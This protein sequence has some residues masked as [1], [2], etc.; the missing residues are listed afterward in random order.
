MRFVAALFFLLLAGQASAATLL[1]EYRLEELQW[2]GAAAEV[3]DTSGNNRH[4]QAIGSPLPTPVDAAPAR[5][6][7]PGTCA[8][9]SFPGPA[10]NGGALSIGG[11]PVS[12]APG[13]KTSVSFWMYW[14]G[15][16]SVMPMGWNRHDLWLVNGHFGFN[17]GNSDVYGISS[18]GLANRWTHV[19][20]EFT[21]GNVAA[22]ALYIDGVA[23][24]LTQRQS[25]PNN[26]YSYANATLR[27]GGWQTDTNYRFS[28]RI[29]EVKVF[30]GQL[31]PVEVTT[32]FNETHV[33]APRLT[34]EWRLDECALGTVV[35][36]V[37][38]ASGNG[39]HGT[40]EGA[41]NTGTG[42]V[43]K[44]GIFNGVTP[45]RIKSVSNFADGITND[46]TI[47]FWVN[48]SGTH[49]IDSQSTS[50][51]GG[52]SGQRYALYPAQ[53][54]DAW[55]AGHAGVGV[56]VG[57][58]GVSVYEHAASYM[59]A[60]LVWP[61]AV[62]G[63]THVAVVY[64]ARQPKL[65]INGAL[66]ATGLTSTYANVHP[67]LRTSGGT[68]TNDGGLGGGNWGWFNGGID[69]FRIYDGALDAAQVASIATV[70]AR[71]C[72]SCAT[73][74]HYR[75]E[76][77]G[78]T[79]VPAEVLDTSGN[80]RHGQA[81]G[82]PLPVPAT[83]SPARAG[84]PGTCGYGDFNGGAL[85]LP[86]A[87]NTAAGAKTTVSFWMYWNGANSV[88][89]VGWFR[90]DLWLVSGHFGFNTAA[91]DVFGI[92]SAG[93]ANRWVH[94]S[95]VFTNGS[96]ASNKLYIDGVPQT[97]TQRQNTPSLGN[98]VVN[99]NLRVSGWQS[100]AGYRF[101]SRIDEV[102]VFDGEMTQS[103]VLA[104]YNA[105]HPCG[106]AVIPGS[107][108]AFET[109][110]PPGIT[111]VVHTKVAGQAF[112]LAIVAIN[113]PKTAVETLFVGDVKIELLDASNNAGAIDANGCRPTWTPLPVFVP[114]T[115]TFAAGDLGRKNITLTEN[116][117]WRDVRVRMTYPAV[118]APL[119]VGCSTDNFAIRPAALVMAA[120]DQ[121]WQTAGIA[122]ALTNSGYPGGT[123]HKAGQPFTLTVTGNNALSA[124]TTNYNGNPVANVVG[125]VL[126]VLGACPTCLLS[127]GAFVGAGG[128]VVSNTATYS[129]VGAFQLQ[130]SDDTFAAV[131][132]GDGSSVAERTAYSTITSVGRFVPDHF[133]L[134]SGT[135]TAA[136]MAGAPPF[137]YMNQPFQNLTANVE[138]QNASGVATVNYHSP[139]FPA[140]LATLAWQ[141]ENA[142]NGTDLSARL[143]VPAPAV[144]WSNGIYAVSTP[145]AFFRRATP[146]NPDGP[147]D[148]L[149]LGVRLNDPDGVAL[150]GLDMNVV[151]AGACAPCTAKAVGA[152]TSVRFGRLRILN[153]HGSELRALPLT[154]R[155]EFWNG[156]GFALNTSDNCTALAAGDFT[157]GNWQSNLNA[158]ETVL[159][160]GGPW[161]AL[162]GLLAGPGLTAPGVGNQGS[163]DVT[164]NLGTRLWLRGR[165]ND[166]V[167]TDADANTMYDDDAVARATF[168][169]YRDRLIYRRE[170]T[171]N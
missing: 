107:F 147:F 123:V 57:T 92:S 46:F 69:E 120:T 163:V 9:G 51:T 23:Q 111:G 81:M 34:L 60:L 13:A 39:N 5:P 116:N 88:M 118:G 64:Q 66:V 128:T 160:A 29:D 102:N 43:C 103:Q 50:G 15:T 167:D 112:D 153:A 70:P 138:A 84:N 6:G 119:A 155:S 75:L 93:L 32:L 8:Y 22:N 148:S 104:Q 40:P 35:G 127:A 108:N 131:D 17:T 65:F 165:W 89:P 130:M 145:A 164:I 20:A 18:A 124:V 110:T 162:G 109:A 82:A 85:N 2:T 27:V 63:W 19:V 114:P 113:A 59:P 137:T 3:R 31:T 49:Q 10:V 152:A 47:A 140:S 100:D 73:L 115:L 44:G 79:G 76:E 132:A 21:N 12:L 146:D 117:A 95:A 38:D 62:S 41:A 161:T 4:G 61:G 52:T 67:G 168:G 77:A 37:S 129:E 16:N 159:A 121:D 94:V 33:C 151:T 136:C 72:A 142:D 135:L 56:S 156:S 90:H 125:F 166:A 86:V 30:D 144:P 96:V 154:V 7:K 91:S 105:T 143:S 14:D 134:T 53:G 158:G 150:N 25:T 87:A 170:V 11:L 98:A 78:W 97:L 71:S 80:F 126:P 28:G 122:R 54:T 36:E 26:T 48:P 106:G 149:R 83:A 99:A 101:R 139:G 55:G 157:L 169:I 133:T 58:N 74:A 68:P 45:T 42:R 24:V 1:G 171:R 141:A